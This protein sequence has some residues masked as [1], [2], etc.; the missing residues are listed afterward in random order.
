MTRKSFSTRAL[1][2]LDRAIDRIEHDAFFAGFEAATRYRAVDDP[3]KVMR[4][5]EAEWTAYVE[6]C[7]GREE[8]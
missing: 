3:L 1:S 8:G 2:R 5:A 4:M 7:A 6:L